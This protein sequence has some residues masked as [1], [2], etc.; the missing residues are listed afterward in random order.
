MSYNIKDQLIEKKGKIVWLASYPKSGNTWLR[1]FLTA[2]I[3][4]DDF[5]I[6]RLIGDAYFPQRHVFDELVGI[7]SRH[8][9][10]AE[11]K[12]YRPAYIDYIV[13]SHLTSSLLFIKIHDAYTSS[14]HSYINEGNTAGIIYI[15]RNPLAIAPSLA[16]HM[17]I[18]L[19][20][21]VENLN[22]EYHLVKENLGKLTPQQF[23]QFLGTWSGH[24]QSWIYNT[25]IPVSLVKYESMLT[26]PFETFSEILSN[27]GV[28][29]STN[30][31]KK[32][33]KMSQFENLKKQ[34]LEA[35]FFNERP[36]RN[37][38]FFRRGK[39][40][41]WKDELNK[42]QISKIKNTHKEMMKKLDYL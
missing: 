20:R 41:A 23:P 6:N 22:S 35:G 33:I 15:V 39:K 10:M 9:T 31:I 11:I 14:P 36:H 13:K 37:N 26:K 3:Q 1:A 34:E 8:L 17:N 40:D 12:A 32:A 2:L 29:A 7:E 38:S 4:P 19:T 28:K 24:V 5:D 16:H 21:A 42:E 25:D 30:Q 27:I 18:P